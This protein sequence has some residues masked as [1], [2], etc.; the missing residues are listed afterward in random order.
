MAQVGKHPNQ[1]KHGTTHRA[2]EPLGDGFDPRRGGVHPTS[3]CLSVG[4]G[5]AAS[6]GSETLHE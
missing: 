1:H 5:A 2:A 6:A 3:S 4:Q